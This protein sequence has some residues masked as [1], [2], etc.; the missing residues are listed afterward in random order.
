[1]VVSVVCVFVFNIRGTPG[2]IRFILVAGV[3]C[4]KRQ[5]LLFAYSFFFF[6]DHKE[7]MFL[8]CVLYVV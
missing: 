4:F 2:I 8:Y 7:K 6:N 1:M 3:G 5:D